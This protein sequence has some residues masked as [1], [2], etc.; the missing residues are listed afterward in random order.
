MYGA[1]STPAISSPFSGGGTSF[2]G[3]LSA[4][5]GR[6]LPN[7]EKMSP[8]ESMKEVFFDIRDGI[9]SLGT[10]FS[11]KISGLNKH[12]A[13]RLETLNDTM[14]NIGSI[15]A[16]DFNL[17]Q[18]VALSD[19]QGNNQS[20]R[21]ENIAKS[22][23]DEEPKKTG[24]IASLK[25]AAGKVG[26][27]YDKMGAKM[28]VALFAG[29]AAALFASM[30]KITP[31]LAKGLKFFKETLIPA[32]KR[33]FGVIMEDLEPVFDRVVTAVSSF[34]G[35]V[36]DFVVGIFTLDFDKIKSGIKKVFIE[37]I[38][39][40]ISAIG[41]AVF[42]VID[43]LLAFIGIGEDSVIRKAVKFIKEAFMAFPENIKKAFN[44]ITVTI[45][46]FFTDMKDNIVQNVQ[47][48]VQGIKDFFS[49]AFNF[50][51]ETIPAKFQEFKDFLK[52]KISLGVDNI[53]DGIV[54][55]VTRIKDTFTMFM[56]NIKGI[57]NA[58]IRTI[59]K[60]PGFDFK[61]FE[62][63][64]LS[65]DV[66]KAHKE[67]TG[68]ASIA[69]NVALGNR[70]RV[71]GNDK[72]ARNYTSSMDTV[73]QGAEGSLDFGLSQKEIVSIEKADQVRAL[74]LQTLLNNTLQ[75]Q[76]LR[77]NAE[78]SKPVIINSSK[79]AGSTTNQT[80]VY[81]AEPATDHNDMTA[82]HLSDAMSA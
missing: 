5:S 57:A 56:N 69:E 1:L 16:D 48:N 65:T 28:K 76:E 17:E 11:E 36:K 49:D 21:D 22:D 42:S 15:A 34:V 44:F 60:I 12:L 59:N 55:V 51:T 14:S 27:G 24:M 23:T 43:G 38:P 73:S 10:I 53:R 18:Q 46:K 50:I 72:R 68:D 32:F 8:L 31:I 29:I 20:K 39:N 61:E 19:K 37:A 58:V 79:V 47:D 4:S 82:K 63:E 2:G 9:S 6:G 7:V 78:T 45:P 40:T 64:P 33:F 54:S 25:G 35:G 70:A 67:A 52:D 74:K 3:A 26:E 30:D 62:K 71:E 81:A 80:Q 66:V 41:G 77:A 75:N 13:F